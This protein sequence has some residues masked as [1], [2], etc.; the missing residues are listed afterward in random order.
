MG[1]HFN[2]TPGLSSGVPMNSIPAFS[3]ALVIKFRV[4]ILADGNPFPASMRL[5]VASPTS[6][7]LAN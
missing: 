5:I 4:F 6:D 1:I 2:R 7:N 3:K